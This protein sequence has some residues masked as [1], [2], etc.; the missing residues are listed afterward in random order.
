MKVRLLLFGLVGAAMG[1]LE[2][3]SEAAADLSRR[4]DPETAATDDRVVGSRANGFHGAGAHFYTWQRERS[5]ALAWVTELAPF[6]HPEAQR[7]G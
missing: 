6:D 4:A 1:W 2:P 7:R 3:Q 5:E